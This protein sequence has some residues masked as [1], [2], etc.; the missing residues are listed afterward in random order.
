MSFSISYG[1]PRLEIGGSD[2][3]GVIV[4]V[5]HIQLHGP[6]NAPLLQNISLYMPAHSLVAVAGLA[7]T[8]TSAL[9]QILAGV[10]RPEDGQILIDGVSLY[11]HR[12]AMIGN[13]GYVSPDMTPHPALTVFEA[14]STA[15]SMRLPRGIKAGMRKMQVDATLELLGLKAEKN[16]KIGGLP[17]LKRYQAEIATE[18]VS[19]PQIVLVDRPVQELDLGAEQSLVAL[20][21]NLTSLGTTVVFATH[22]SRSMLSADFLI[23]LDAAGNLV[24]FGPPGDLTRFYDSMRS[25]ITQLPAKPG[26]EEIFAVLENP[27]SASATDWPALFQTSPFYAKFVDEPINRKNRDLM[28]EEHPLSRL[29]GQNV[30]RKP[31]VRVPRSSGIQQ[32]FIYLARNLKILARDPFGLVFGFV[33]PV[34]IAIGILLTASPQL[35]DPVLGDADSIN[36]I[37]STL[38]FVA[39]FIASFCQVRDVAKENAVY[40]R[41]RQLSAG[42]IPYVLAKSSLVIPIAIYQ[43]VVVTTAYFA[44][45][46]LGGGISAIPGFLI[47]MFLAAVAGGMIGLVAS[48]LASSV[49]SGVAWALV[50]LLPQ[51]FFSG[52]FIPL[53]DLNPVGQAISMVMPV[54][55]AF[56][57]LVTASKYGNDVAQDSCWTMPVDKL[58][59]VTD[60][61]KGSCTCM[62]SNIFV[63]CNFPGIRQS[64][65]SLLDQPQPVEPTPNNAMNQIPVQPVLRAGETLDQFAGEISQYTLQLEQYQGAVSN[66]L[67]S[68]RQFI[69][70]ITAWQKLQSYAMGIGEAQIANEIKDYGQIYNIDLGGHWLTLIIMSVVLGIL[71]TGIQIRKGRV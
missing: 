40:R 26:I 23:I 24:W 55:Y 16:Q 29:R 70:D 22:L 12:E 46:G 37:L 41:E 51:V 27:D 43:G 2:S 53:H 31:P 52:S 65:T 20:Y 28:L 5:H 6:K 9:L 15:A 19:R 42:V 17:A 61:Q 11:E 14:L 30:E 62:G 54:H 50:L 18:I 8:G 4:E 39:V 1:L 32:Y 69:G 49:Q 66:Y 25:K 59:T 33:A 57:A 35:Y 38:V 13:I 64:V 34:L 60:S 3:S 7:G 47:T 58:Q 44:A 10:R 45:V 48:S 56:E 67:S 63:S 68:L 36:L 21:R 71:F